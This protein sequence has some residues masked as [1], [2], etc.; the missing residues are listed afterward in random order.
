MVSARV[1]R[2]LMIIALFVGL[3]S[4]A[5]AAT[6]YDEA[7]SGD[8]SNTGLSP[9][10]VALSL[11][12]N[13]VFGATGS[14]VVGGVLVFD[15]DYFTVTVPAG[16][17]LASLVQLPGTLTSGLSFLGVEA[18][19]QVTVSPTPAD[20]TGLLGWV[21]YSAAT[22]GADLLPIMGVPDFGSTGFVPPLG[23]GDYSFWIQELAVG[24]FPYG[25]D[26]EI[27]RVPAPPTAIMAVAGF[28]M[29]AFA[30]R[31]RRATCARAA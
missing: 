12:S 1:G 8:L 21:H 11:G 6:V 13:E 19:S 29:I 30:L 7:V 15:R 5:F 10:G 23:P 27:T 28:A 16:F 26:L 17:Q 20:A 4:S 9:T 22:S 31:R 25:F 3:A 18:G 14:A 24:R 2:L